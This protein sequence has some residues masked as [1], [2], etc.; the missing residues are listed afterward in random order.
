MTVQRDWIGEYA[1]SHQHPVNR[2]CHTVGIPMIAASVLMGGA[3]VFQPRLRK[4]AL[5]LFAAGWALQF[6]G[7]AFEGR[8]PEFLHDPRFLFVGLRWWSAK[9]RGRA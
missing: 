5:A 8:P 3:S 4:P 6:V 1:R 2:A 7:H 9:V